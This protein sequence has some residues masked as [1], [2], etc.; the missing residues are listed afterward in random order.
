MNLEPP[1]TLSRRAFLTATAAAGLVRANPS[2]F[3]K[4][5]PATRPPIHAIGCVAYSFNYA[6]GVLKP[7]QNR[8][9]E[10]WD[11]F[12]FID[13]TKQAGGEV[14]QMFVNMLTKIDDAT[15]ARLRRHA[16]ERDMRIEVHGGNPFNPT[17]ERAMRQAPLLGARTVMGTL[18]MFVR[19]DKTKTLAEWD[20]FHAQCR[21]RLRRLAIPAR[22]LGITLAV[23]NHFDFT[24]RELRTLM[25]EVD[26]PHVGVMFDSGNSLGTLDDPLEAAE[27]LGPF[28]KTTHIKDYVIRETPRGFSL[29]MM[30]LGTGSLRLA[31]ILRALDRHAPT[32]DF[33][34]Q[35]Y[36]DAE[37]EVPWLD[38]GFFA[39]YRGKSAAEIA[40]TLR[41]IR[42]KPHDPSAF[43]SSEFVR[44]LPH[45]EH[46]AF[47]RER[48]RKC[49][50]YL[51]RR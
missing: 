22:E 25:E 31:E 43:R 18:G 16:D 34:V 36:N 20:A 3:D 9:G 6:I 14:A 2:S 41:H 7:Y 19:P 15:L 29:R 8:T 42:A 40:A 49:F 51:R 5:A 38:D 28:V 23:A 10:R 17:F 4:A 39:A 21:E 11:A 30:P 44:D 32:V 12:R 13:E 35:M 45:E 24:T 46:L 1:A 50:D 47:E 37:T 27:I 48:L 26:S 33:I